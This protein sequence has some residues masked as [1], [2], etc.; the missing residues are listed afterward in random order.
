MPRIVMGV[1]LART[2]LGEGRM[3]THAGRC[4]GCGH[5][6]ELR[7]VDRDHGVCPDCGTVNAMVVLRL[8]DESSVAITTADARRTRTL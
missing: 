1:R 3:P 5:V 4:Q 6:V 7:D 2:E 8:D